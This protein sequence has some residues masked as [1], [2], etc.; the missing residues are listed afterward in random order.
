VGPVSSLGTDTL[1]DIAAVLLNV[2]QKRGNKE[3]MGMCKLL[4]TRDV[5]VGQMRPKALAARA[6]TQGRA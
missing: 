2:M 6:S 3:Y 5:V 1:P 4:H